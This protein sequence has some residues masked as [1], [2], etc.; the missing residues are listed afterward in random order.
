MQ[1]SILLYKL[2]KKERQS[3][4]L[5]LLKESLTHIFHQ[6]TSGILVAWPKQGCFL[7]ISA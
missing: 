3:T 1:L 5:T 4:D 7:A 6:S 2:G